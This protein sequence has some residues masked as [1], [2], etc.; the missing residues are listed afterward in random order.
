MRAWSRRG[1]L[2]ILGLGTAL[3]FLVQQAEAGTFLLKKFLGRP[4]RETLPIT[5][6]SEFY[7]YHY[8]NTAYR[9]VKDL[10]IKKWSLNI[11]GK[12]RQSLKLTYPQILE[13]SPTKMMATIEC[14]E[15]PVGGESIGNAQWQGIQLDS[16]LKEAGVLVGVKDVVMKAADG[17][18]DS[19]KL[20]RAMTGNVL[21]AYE[22]NNKQLPREHGFPIRAVVP[23]IYGMKNVKWITE[24]ELVD[25]D[26]Q[27]YWQQRGWSD[28]AR[29]RLT[30]RIDFPGHYQELPLKEH[31]LRG[32]A[33]SGDRGIR[34]VELSSN[35]GKSWKEVQL[36]QALSKFSWVTWKFRWSPT[37]PGMVQ[38]IVRATDQ[39]GRQQT[40]DSEPAFPN[41]PSGLHSITVQIVG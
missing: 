14:I 3:S 5:P 28:T 1:F 15:N 23:G 27:G 33:F 13:L 20:D 24:I 41:G 2:K 21:L 6:N 32:I 17:Y 19:I 39:S 34:S 40:E 9:L 18:S 10:D 37:S 8:G 38:L 4:P 30:S 16:L 26:Y 29:V 22:M 31:V 25:H 11:T 36:D 35:H 7:V 12:V